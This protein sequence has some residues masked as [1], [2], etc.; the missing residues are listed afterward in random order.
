M[1]IDRSGIVAGLAAALLTAALPP[2]TAQEGFPL[3]GTWRGEWGENGTHVVVVMSW[4]E[5]LAAMRTGSTTASK[6][7]DQLVGA[8]RGLGDD[9]PVQGNCALTRKL[10]AEALV[11]WLATDPTG[12]GDA[13]FLIIGDLNSY[14]KEDPIDAL[15]SAGYTD[16]IAQFNG[17]EA[18]SYVFDGKVGYLDHALADAALLPSITGA[19]DWHINADEPDLIDY[20]MS[21]K[22]DAQDDL[23]EPNA[24]RSS[25]HDPVIVGIDF[26]E[27][28]PTCAGLPAT[29]VGTDG[30]DILF[31]TSGADVIVALGGNDIIFA[32]GGDPLRPPSLQPPSGSCAASNTETT[33][34]ILSAMGP[35]SELEPSSGVEPSEN[36]LVKMKRASNEGRT[37]AVSSHPPS[38]ARRPTIQDLARPI[39]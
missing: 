7:L 14:D 36:R 31:G 3:D 34:S 33:D 12:S 16:L 9:D 38:G 24:F 21:F 35:L 26:P 4:D 17:P 5:V 37:G 1:G 2:A 15:K 32:R 13:D 18:Y 39:A 10:G 25:D 30:S 29:I 11:D 27:P 20:D 23:Y 19:A 8:C 28:V 22:Q 6:D